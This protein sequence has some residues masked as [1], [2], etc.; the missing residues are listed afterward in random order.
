MHRCSLQNKD[1]S[2]LLWLS[3]GAIDSWCKGIW[4]TL[5]G[6]SILK[7]PWKNSL[8]V[9]LYILFIKICS[10]CWQIGLLLK[11]HVGASLMASITQ[12]KY[13]TVRWFEHTMLIQH[14]RPL[15]GC[16]LKENCTCYELERGTQLLL[17]ALPNWFWLTCFKMKIEMHFPFFFFL[18]R[19]LLYLAL[20]GVSFLVITEKCIITFDYAAIKDAR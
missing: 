9:Y 17:T 10:W 11:I 14:Q 8:P 20:S 19:N 2:F 12:F 18:G 1:I 16:L 3:F 13:T 5:L 4:E 15:L 6:C 7:S